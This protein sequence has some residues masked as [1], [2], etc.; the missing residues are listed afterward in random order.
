MSF[1][2]TKRRISKIREKP[3]NKQKTMIK[4]IVLS[5]DRQN[6]KEYNTADDDEKMSK[7]KKKTQLCVNIYCVFRR[8]KKNVTGFREFI[9]IVKLKKDKRNEDNDVFSVNNWLLFKFFFLALSY[10]LIC[11]PFL[12]LNYFMTFRICRKTCNKFNLN[13]CESFS[14]FKTQK[15]LIKN[16]I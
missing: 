2:F 15:W 8:E 16:F 4:V 1:A 14:S 7:K 11:G 13:I 10:N 5:K 6:K 9:F 12:S 3:V